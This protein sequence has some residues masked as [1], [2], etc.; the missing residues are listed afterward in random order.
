MRPPAFW[1]DRQPGLAARLLTPLSCLW[2]IGGRINARRSEPFRAERPV[3]CIGNVNLGGTGKTPVAI[4]V[5]RALVAA[6][7]YPHFIS[8]GYGGALTARTTR[9]EPERHSALDVGDEPLLLARTA[10]TW[11]G[12]DRV[13][14]AKAAVAAGASHL[15]LD[16]GFQNNSLIK[17]RSFLVVDSAIGFGNGCVVPAGPLRERVED[18]LS[19]ADAVILLGDGPAPGAIE[20]R[21]IPC[22]RGRLTPDRPETL[23][24]GSR[25]MAFAGIGRPEKFFATLRDMHLDIVA[26]RA[27]PDHHRY[28]EA[29]T[30]AILAESQRLQAIAVTTEKDFVK[31]PPVIQNRILAVGVHVTWHDAT[32]VSLISFATN[33]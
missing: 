3:I 32:P 19:R 12:A 16:D 33:Q 14:S 5:G 18:A 6:G 7:A 2:Q 28:S 15:I 27:F 9:V 10:P 24:V 21:K 30:S 11:I 20:S 26:T 8:R 13:T 25:V 22:F 4:E 31:L 23:P 29:D 17:D 1:F